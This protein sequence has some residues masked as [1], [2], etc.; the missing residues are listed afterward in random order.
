MTSANEEGESDDCVKYKIPVNRR[1]LSG[2]EH[3]NVETEEEVK[4]G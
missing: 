4:G 2:T 3:G 1:H